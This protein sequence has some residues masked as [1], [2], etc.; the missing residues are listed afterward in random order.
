MRRG[1]GGNRGGTNRGCLAHCLSPASSRQPT[2]FGFVRRKEQIEELRR[3]S[4]CG[5]VP[6]D[7]ARCETLV[8]QW[9]RAGV[10]SANGSVL[11]VYSGT[12]LSA[13]ANPRAVVWYLTDTHVLTVESSFAGLRYA[14]KEYPIAQAKVS[15]SDYIVSISA[16]SARMR[17]IT[18]GATSGPIFNPTINASA[19]SGAVE[20]EKAIR[21]AQ[22]ALRNLATSS[23]SQEGP[24]QAYADTVSLGA[25]GPEGWRADPWGR[26]EYRYRRP[27]A[28]GNEG[29]TARVVTGAIGELDQ[30]GQHPVRLD[31]P[32]ISYFVRSDADC[33]QQ[34]IKAAIAAGSKGQGRFE[35][36]DDEHW[37]L[38][39]AA[40]H[41]TF[42]GRERQ[43]YALADKPHLIVTFG[44]KFPPF[45]GAVHLGAHTLSNRPV[46][47]QEGTNV[48]DLGAEL[49]AFVRGILDGMY[50]MPDAPT[51]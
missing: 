5:G 1:R 35:S 26:F 3:L 33:F 49:A 18:F 6:L 46:H 28:S 32:V 50:R 9:I 12:C 11:G 4:H 17:S 30:P 40:G 10:L 15:R 23:S 2:T 36:T 29:W 7:D 44:S 51:G 48:G 25:C 45:A 43:V 13:M 14:W 34:E 22:W 47:Y 27:Y 39:P 21:T 42:A 8:S 20:L 41:I 38:S 16:K 24:A 37:P 19:M 31:R